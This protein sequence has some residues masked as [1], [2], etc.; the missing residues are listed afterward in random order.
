MAEFFDPNIIE[1]LGDGLFRW[2]GDI[3]CSY[4]IKGT[5]IKDD[6]VIFDYGVYTVVVSWINS[7]GKRTDPKWERIYPDSS[8]GDG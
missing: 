1:D 3:F 6:C 8:G 2:C 7:G 5:E 4:P